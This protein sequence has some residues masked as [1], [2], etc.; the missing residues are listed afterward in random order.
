MLLR[1][2]VVGGNFVASRTALL[3][4]NGFDTSIAFYGEDADIGRRLHTQGRMRFNTNFRVRT[5]GRRIAS[6]GL[7]RT[8]M[9]YIG[10]FLSDAIFHKPVTKSYTDI[11]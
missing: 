8:G 9:I 2:M 3:S 1:Y 10:N 6:Q 5:S 4:I 11:R 7:M